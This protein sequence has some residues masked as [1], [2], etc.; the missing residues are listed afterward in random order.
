[1]VNRY[2]GLGLLLITLAAAP[3]AVAKSAPSGPCH[4][5]STAAGMTIVAKSA[6]GVVFQNARGIF[7]GCAYKPARV[8]VLDICCQSERVRVAGVFAAYV[9]QGT[10]IGDETDKIGVYDLRSGKRR[11]IRKLSP[12]SEGG[13]IEID[14]GNQITIF[15]VARDGGVAWIQTT[16]NADASPSPVLQVRAAGGRHR[17]ER[18][19]DEGPAISRSFLS[20]DGFS[21][22]FGLRWTNDGV[23]NY[24]NLDERF[25]GRCN[26]L[27][28]TQ[29]LRTESVLVVRRKS[30]SFN[31]GTEFVGQEFFG[32]TLPSGVATSLGTSGTTYLYENGRRVGTYGRE[33]LTIGNSAGTY[34]ALEV[35]GGTNNFNYG[36]GSIVDLTYGVSHSY[37]FFNSEDLGSGASSPNTEPL[38]SRLSET[39][40]F[41]GVFGPDI[42]GTQSGHRV[43]GMSPTGKQQVLDEAADENAIPPSSL[44]ITG[45]TVSWMNNGAAKSAE[46]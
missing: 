22:P 36:S 43:I 32:C 30:H 14:T 2:A 38:A 10:A 34:A 20:I 19:V 17:W 33:Q 1:M 44:A 26:N 12:N 35:A 9:A 28:G 23:R 41:A 4:K 40:V 16:R 39:G 13:G 18:I 24:T 25:V 15:R 27:K 8:R 42:G 21:V 46:L 11:A 45:R 29:V 37:Y 31:S 6:K 3:S 5:A 7:R